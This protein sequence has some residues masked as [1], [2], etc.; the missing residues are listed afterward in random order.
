MTG[1]SQSRQAVE[2]RWDTAIDIVLNSGVMYGY[3]E[4]FWLYVDGK[5]TEDELRKAIP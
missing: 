4:D 5:L 3:I 2:K 1:R